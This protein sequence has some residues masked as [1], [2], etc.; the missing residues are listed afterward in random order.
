ML[1]LVLLRVD[2]WMDI[3]KEGSLTR[4]RL[5]Y[6]FGP[7]HFT[8]TPEA[9]SDCMMTQGPLCAVSADTV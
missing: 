4:P 1:L 9:T 6:P 8:A 5:P 7:Q 2:G 3:W